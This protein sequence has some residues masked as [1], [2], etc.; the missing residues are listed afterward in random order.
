MGSNRKNIGKGCAEWRDEIS[1]ILLADIES[2]IREAWE[3]HSV[4]CRECAAL[5][6]EDLIVIR[7][8]QE[9]ATPE[10]VNI[11][12]AVMERLHNPSANSPTIRPR[13]LA[14]GFGSAAL[15]FFLGFLISGWSL[16]PS[17]AAGVDEYF[18]QTFVE[19]DTGIDSLVTALVQYN[20]EIEDE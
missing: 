13:Y 1:D 5:V 20:N 16:E 4:S 9:L 11:S 19:L 8:I 7:R 3:K 12:T 14:W 15:G 10:H 6:E 18:E 17:V 2:E